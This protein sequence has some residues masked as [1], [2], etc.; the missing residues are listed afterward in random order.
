MRIM[1]LFHSMHPNRPKIERSPLTTI[2]DQVLAS[3]RKS[4]VN[5]WGAL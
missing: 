1:L 2:P 4:N 5:K 3:R